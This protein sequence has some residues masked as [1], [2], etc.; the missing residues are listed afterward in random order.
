MLVLVNGTPHGYFAWKRGVRQ[1]DPLSPILFC[2]AEEVLSRAISLAV[3]N[4]KLNLMIGSK[5]VRMLSHSLY[6]DDVK[7]F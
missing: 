7:L 6:A 1:G 2:L 3:A 4:G 5:G